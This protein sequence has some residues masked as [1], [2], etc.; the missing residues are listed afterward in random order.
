ML[1]RF[2]KT[3]IS[4]LPDRHPLR[5]L[6]VCVVSAVPGLD[7]RRNKE[8]RRPPPT[9]IGGPVPANR[10]PRRRPSHLVRAEGC[11]VISS[12]PLFVKS[13]RKHHD[14]RLSVICLLL[15]A[16]R[17]FLP[18]ENHRPHEAAGA[19]QQRDVAANIGGVSP[20]V[21]ILPRLRFL[22]YP[23]NPVTR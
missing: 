21:D 3:L 11:C 13:C 18:I 20:N 2:C 6:D 10:M 8:E 5:P 23:P 7:L 16:L 4:P 14:R 19:D 1:E 17:S 22:R 15:T 12:C 9:P